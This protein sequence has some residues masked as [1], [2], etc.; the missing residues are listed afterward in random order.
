MDYYAN[1]HMPM[2]ASLYGSKMKSWG[3]EKGLSGRTSEEP[4]TYIAVGY[5]IFEDINDYH[6]GFAAN[7]EKILG[8]IPNY[9]DIQPTLQISEIIK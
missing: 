7:A 9:T 3:I 4:V 6:E 5:F 2:V 1:E 8:D